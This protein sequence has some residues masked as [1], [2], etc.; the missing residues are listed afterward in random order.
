MAYLQ[1]LCRGHQ[2]IENVPCW[3]IAD[4]PLALTNV[5]LS[6]IALNPRGRATLSNTERKRLHSIAH[7]CGRLGGRA[8]RRSQRRLFQW[9]NS[10]SL[11]A[12]DRRL[13]LTLLHLPST[14]NLQQ[15]SLPSSQRR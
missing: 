15:K 7:T 3:H 6:N 11:E 8:G 13:Q 12:S 4:V 14:P 9:V 1:R 2:M 5:F 10:S